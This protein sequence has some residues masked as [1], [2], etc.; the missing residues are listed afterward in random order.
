MCADCHLPGTLCMWT[1]CTTC[2]ESCASAAGECG[3][4]GGA[5]EAGLPLLFVM[6]LIVLGLFT[7][8]GIFYS[9][10]VAT[11][12][13]QRIWQRHYHI[14]AKRMLTKVSWLTCSLCL[15]VMKACNTSIVINDHSTKSR[16]ELMMELL[17]TVTAG[18]FVLIECIFYCW[19]S[20]QA[21][22]PLSSSFA[23]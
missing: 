12:V 1:D 22:H 11:M 23:L 10:L 5:G 4:L 17:G 15:S 2:F 9:V 6:A 19:I 8:I 3:C 18:N 21:L 16:P 14:L 7:V 20:W 13:G